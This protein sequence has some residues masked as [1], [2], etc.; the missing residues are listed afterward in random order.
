MNPGDRH[1][2]KAPHLYHMDVTEIKTQYW[3]IRSAVFFLF[4]ALFWAVMVM[5]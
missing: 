2:P 1:T 4:Y 5:P 3:A